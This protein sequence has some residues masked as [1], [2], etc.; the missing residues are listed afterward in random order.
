MNIT[1][2]RTKSSKIKYELEKA[3]QLNKLLLKDIACGFL[4][5]V[6][7]SYLG[8]HLI[9]LDHLIT[10]Y[11]KER[12]ITVLERRAIRKIDKVH[13]S[14]VIFKSRESDN[15]IIKRWIAETETESEIIKLLNKFNT[16]VEKR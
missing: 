11:E 1:L 8:I 4:F 7:G 13:L 2:E 6:I 15:N 5:D 14:M 10:K 9:T 16:I 3:I 12:E